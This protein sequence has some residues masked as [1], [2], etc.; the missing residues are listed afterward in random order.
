MNKTQLEDRLV[1]FAVNTIK[2][3]EGTNKTYAGNHLSKQ[4]IRSSS[5]PALNYAEAQGAESKRDFLHKIKIVLKEL[6]E[7]HVCLKIIE[8]LNLLS[9]SDIIPLKNE[10]NELIAIFVKNAETVQKNI[11]PKSSI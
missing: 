2:K 11:H 6:R 4:L 9:P 1:K 10:C 5:S 3:V 8:G 7:S